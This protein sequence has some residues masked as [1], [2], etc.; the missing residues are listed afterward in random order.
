MLQH[1]HSKSTVSRRVKDPVTQVTT[2]KDVPC[3]LMMEKYNKSMGGVDKSDQ[4]ISYHSVLTQTVNY[5]KTC[6]FHLLDVA[7]VNCHIC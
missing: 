1:G 6:F 7:T 5:W 2:S 4:F 3:P